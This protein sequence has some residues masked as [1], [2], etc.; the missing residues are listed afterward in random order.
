MATFV[1]RNFKPDCQVQF[2]CTIEGG[3]GDGFELSK[4]PRT[5]ESNGE[6]KV[7]EQQ[8]PGRQ[9]GEIECSSD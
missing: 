7:T 5:L 4:P 6:E 2:F 1:S 3:R 8:S 9:I